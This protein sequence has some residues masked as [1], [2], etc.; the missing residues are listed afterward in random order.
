MK[1]FLAPNRI[2]S[3]SSKPSQGSPDLHICQACGHLGSP[4]RGHAGQLNRELGLW[5]VA[6]FSALLSP[7][8]ACVA[9]PAALGYSIWRTCAYYKRCRN[10]RVKDVT[11]PLESERGSVLYRSVFAIS[12]DDQPWRNN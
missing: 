7:L 6:A 4:E 12:L 3:H 1:T 9:A 5:C 8:L 2:A 11:L 10:C